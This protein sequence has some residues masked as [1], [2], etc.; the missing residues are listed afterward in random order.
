MKR[1][2]FLTLPV[3]AVPL[4]GCDWHGHA[5][6]EVFTTYVEMLLGLR[7]SLAGLPA[8]D[9]LSFLDVDLRESE[10]VR[11]T[12]LVCAVQTAE[13]RNSVPDAASVSKV[14]AQARQSAAESLLQRNATTRQPVLQAA[15][16]PARLDVEM[17][18]DA[19]LRR[20]FMPQGDP[21][22]GW[23]SLAQRY[24][25]HLG[26]SAFSS[27][28]FSADGQQAV[29]AYEQSHAPLHG[30]GHLVLMQQRQGSWVLQAHR[31]LWVS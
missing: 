7:P 22:A 9:D 1:R 25:G 31:Q 27:A 6:A 12:L 8:W 18:S 17:L 23:E 10:A 15:R 24:P 21:F 16:L 14:L 13:F 2:A 29:F 28:G 5:Q 26:I 11:R 20:L 3:A 30:T 4:T 19:A